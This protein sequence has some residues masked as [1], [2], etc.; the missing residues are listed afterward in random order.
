MTGLLHPFVWCEK[1]CCCNFKDS[2]CSMTRLA[3]QRSLC[4]N[5]RVST[6]GGVLIELVG[7]LPSPIGCKSF[8]TDEGREPSPVFTAPGYEWAPLVLTS[9]WRIFN[10][11]LTAQGRSSPYAVTGDKAF[12]ALWAGRGTSRSPRSHQR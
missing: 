7:G 3:Q 10:A 8:T 11:P 4:E 2:Q 6:R 5:C 1:N 9:G 12:T